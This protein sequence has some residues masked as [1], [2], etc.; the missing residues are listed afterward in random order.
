MCS[1]LGGQGRVLDSLE[2]VLGIAVSH[3]VGLGK[4]ILVKSNECS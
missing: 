4:Q 2:L 3:H 1:A